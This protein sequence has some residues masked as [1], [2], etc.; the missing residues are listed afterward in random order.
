M[1]EDGYLKGAQEMHRL[2]EELKDGINNIPGLRVIGP[3][4][5]ANIAYV[6]DHNETFDI[7]KVA[8]ALETMGWKNSFRLRRPHGLLIQ[9]GVRSKFDAQ[10]YLD[11]L[12]K[13][14]QLAKT[15]PEE[16]HGLAKIY[17]DAALA[18]GAVVEGIL[19]GYADA[20]YQ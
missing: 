4:E 6:A 1:G 15:H 13:A 3:P 8:D 20:L 16:I 2:F 5:A 17:K 18:P 11:D 10:K 19:A 12:K 7:M 9:V 14:V